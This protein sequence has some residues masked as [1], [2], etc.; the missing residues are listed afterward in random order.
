MIYDI[1]L[2]RMKIKHYLVILHKQPDPEHID[3]PVLEVVVH[4]GYLEGIL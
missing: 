1:R 4:T 3:I 2:L